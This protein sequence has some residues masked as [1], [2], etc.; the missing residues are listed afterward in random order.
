[1]ILLAGSVY[2]RQPPQCDDVPGSGYE[3]FVPA[4]AT[5]GLGQAHL[6]C[7]IVSLS[8]GGMAGDGSRA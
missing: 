4:A 2:A 3:G 1:M 6:R 8:D 7:G 5:A